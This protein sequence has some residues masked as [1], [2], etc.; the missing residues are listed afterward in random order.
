[1]TELKKSKVKVK[2]VILFTLDWFI[3][4]NVKED[5]HVACPTA[6]TAVPAPSPVVA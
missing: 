5:E 1:M 3:I 4:D 2:A 6:P